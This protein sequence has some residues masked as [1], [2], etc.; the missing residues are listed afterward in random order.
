MFIG[1]CLDTSRNQ[2]V[3]KLKNVI[4]TIFRYLLHFTFVKKTSLAF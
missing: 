3:Y 2:S 4:E 1:N